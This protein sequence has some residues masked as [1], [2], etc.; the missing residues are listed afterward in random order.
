[1][2]KLFNNKFLQFTICLVL[3]TAFV[4]VFLMRSR[5]ISPERFSDMFYILLNVVG[6]IISFV[7]SVCIVIGLVEGLSKSE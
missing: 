5:W 3:L 2:K 1:M 7:I 4:F 6:A